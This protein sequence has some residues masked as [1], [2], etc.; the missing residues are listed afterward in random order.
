MYFYC[1]DGT[2]EEALTRVSVIREGRKKFITKNSCTNDVD[3]WSCNHF[4]NLFIRSNGWRYPKDQETRDYIL[5]V[6][7][8]YRPTWR[9]TDLMI[10]SQ[11]LSQCAANFITLDAVGN[12][13]VIP[14]VTI[15]GFYMSP[16]V[17]D[18]NPNEN[19]IG[20]AI[21][22]IKDGRVWHHDGRKR[23]YR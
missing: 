6:H 23:P 22:A 5:S 20:F 8:V 17:G 21:L 4:K 10:P 1:Y 11:M 16:I 18:F 9:H 19:Y 12:P 2:T 7:G 15:T 3:S 13:I 14:K